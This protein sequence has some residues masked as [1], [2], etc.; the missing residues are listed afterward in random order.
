MASSEDLSYAAAARKWHETR[1]GVTTPLSRP[2]LEAILAN[3]QTTAQLASDAT[4]L[5]IHLY[6]EELNFHPTTPNTASATAPNLPPQSS[7]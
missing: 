7:V 3:M 5:F 6:L 4:T 2:Q 1:G